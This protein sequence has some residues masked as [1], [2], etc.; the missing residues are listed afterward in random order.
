MDT[1]RDDGGDQGDRLENHRGE[2]GEVA[3]PGGELKPDREQDQAEDY[4]EVVV[5]PVHASM[6]A[7]G[8]DTIA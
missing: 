6:I 5:D 2:P 7:R 4:P 8:Q 3:L 1:R